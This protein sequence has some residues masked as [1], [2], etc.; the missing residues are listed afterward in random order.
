MMAFSK[1]SDKQCDIMNPKFIPP[2]RKTK[3]VFVQLGSPE[4]PTPKALRK[5]LREF[6]GDPRLIDLN[7]WL[8]SHFKSVSFHEEGD[9]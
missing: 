9:S 8:K 5:Y 3:V 7:P 4:S 6:L 1:K 2:K